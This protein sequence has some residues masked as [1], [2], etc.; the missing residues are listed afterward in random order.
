MFKMVQLLP[1][2]AT[3]LFDGAT[4]ISWNNFT[5]S[6]R[7]IHYFG[8]TISFWLNNFMNSARY[9]PMAQ[10]HLGL[11]QHLSSWHNILIQVASKYSMLVQATP[12]FSKPLKFS[13]NH[14]LEDPFLC[15][16]FFCH[17]FLYLMIH[18]FQ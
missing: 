16:L 2:G 5:P 18:S 17:L 8:A 15:H 14:L 7:T 10:H 12:S 1:L 3:P 13:Q 6:W 4:S 9:D 11:A